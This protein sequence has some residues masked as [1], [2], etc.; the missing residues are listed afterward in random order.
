MY[1]ISINYYDHDT[2]SCL[3]EKESKVLKKIPGI[4]HHDKSLKI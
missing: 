2:S 3:F 1:H 4:L